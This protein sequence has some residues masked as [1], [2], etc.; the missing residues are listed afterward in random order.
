[1]FKNL[2]SLRFSILV[3]CSFFAFTLSLKAQN[4]SLPIK[5]K[6]PIFKNIIAPSAFIVL[7]FALNNTANEKNIT[8]DV[9]SI[10]GHDYHNKIDDFTQA[11]PVIEMYA[12][13][14]IGIPAKNHWFDQTKN[15]A[16]S[17]I[18]SGAI[19]QSLKRGLNKTRP[20]GA[21]YSFPSGH[22]GTAFTNASVLYQEFKETSPILA[23]SGYGF[24]VTTGAFR[25]INNTHWTSDVLASVGISIL[26][27]NL[28]YHFEPLK[29]WNPF[30]KTKG[31]TLVP[32]YNQHETGIF[33]TKRF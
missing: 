5:R 3:I 30:K 2:T 8:K 22:T 32:Y 16:I 28:V 6:L 27:T 33:L 25:V 26:T 17:T 11:V 9:R 10:V 19:I 31:L 1:M 12:A 18:V 4:D 13:D 15:L 7:G 14:I 24:A 29:N 23:Y 20:N 21:P